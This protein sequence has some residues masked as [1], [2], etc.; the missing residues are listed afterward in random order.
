[1]NDLR[2]RDMHRLSHKPV[3]INLILRADKSTEG[4]QK[5]VAFGFVLDLDGEALMAA[6]GGKD[7]HIVAEATIGRAF[8]ATAAD[9]WNQGPEDILTAGIPAFTSHAA[10]LND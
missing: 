7:I 5:L 6:S 2:L 10:R 3:R 1:M 8:S 9:T 4:E